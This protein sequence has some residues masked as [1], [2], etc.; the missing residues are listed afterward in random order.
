MTSPT[1]YDRWV[2]YPAYD[3]EGN[4]IGTI[5]QIFYDDQSN[6]PEWVSVTTGFFGTKQAVI[7]INGSSDFQDGLQVPYTKA[8][9]KDAPHIDTDTPMT[10]DD[11]QALYGHYGYDYTDSTSTN[12]GYGKDY[13][14]SN[15]ADRDFRY[16]TYDDTRQNWSDTERGHDEVV[17]E[18]TAVSE[19][20]QKVQRPETVR[21]RKY[22]HTEM[23]PVTKEEVRVEKDTDTM[24]TTRKR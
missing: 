10:R 23:V 15:R 4:K 5:D 9:V 20:V 13:R 21:L 11:E 3:V 24:T 7:P 8:Q 12:Y 6:R 19:D 22:Q 1:S 16:R 17:A 14:T 2:G 18:A